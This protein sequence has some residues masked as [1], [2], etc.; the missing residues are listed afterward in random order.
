MVHSLESGIPR[1]RQLKDYIIRKIDEGE[2]AADTQVASENRLATQ[3]G[4][5]RMTANRALRELSE[6]GILYRVQGLGSFVAERKPESSLLEIRN[7]ADEI[8]ARGHEHSS[9][10]IEQNEVS[11]DLHVCHNLELPAGSTVYHSIII[12]FENRAPIQYEER[13]VNKTAVPGYIDADFSRITPNIYLTQTA[14]LQ[15]AE[16]KIESVKADRLIAE[17][18]DIGPGEPCLLVSRRTWSGGIPVC[19]ARLHHPGSRYRIVGKF[20]SK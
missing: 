11:A 6:A 9:R 8:R 5:S 16:N 4:V 19:Y 20:S 15:S 3:F 14:P 12:H 1:Y 10:L 7:I 2:W 13:F 18:L 17:A